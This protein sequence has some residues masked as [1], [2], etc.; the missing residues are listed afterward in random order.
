V[1]ALDDRSVTATAT[2]AY[3][4]AIAQPTRLRILNCV[5]AAPLYVSE[6]VAILALPQ[7]T[8][9]RHLRVLRDAA[10]L[11]DIPIPPYAIYSLVPQPDTRE[12]LLRALLDAALTEDRFRAERA[13][14]LTR[15]RESVRPRTATAAA[16]A[17]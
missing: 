7:P 8:V 16:N 14:A 11:R 3:I 2:A 4:A 17:G 15:S 9:S 13:A 12:R 5:A 6:L 10:V 1:N